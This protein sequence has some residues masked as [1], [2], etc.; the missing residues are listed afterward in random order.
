[1]RHSTTAPAC[2]LS[3]RCANAI[4]AS[5]PPS[6]LLSAR[7]RM[8]TYLR[9]TTR[10]SAQMISDRIPRTAGLPPALPAAPAPPQ[11]YPHPIEGRA[12]TPPPPPP[13]PPPPHPPH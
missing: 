10:M 12:P 7:S 13:A 6:P 11:Q 9:V 2:L 4:S 5:V 3:A 1:M 8:T